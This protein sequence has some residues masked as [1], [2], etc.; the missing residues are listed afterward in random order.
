MSKPTETVVEVD[1]DIVIDDEP[2][3]EMIENLADEE[4]SPPADVPDAV[5][6]LMAHHHKQVENYVDVRMSNMM[7]KMSEHQKLMTQHT[8]AI[9]NVTRTIGDHTE[10]ILALGKQ[11]QQIMAHLVQQ[12]QPKLEQRPIKEVNPDMSAMESLFKQMTPPAPVSQEAP[13]LQVPPQLQGLVTP[14]MLAAFQKKQPGVI[15][16]TLGTVGNVLH[17]V[18]DTAAFLAESAVDLIT[19]GKAKRTK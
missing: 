13:A 15:D 8:E 1:T 14:E 6:K 11:Q 7:T 10:M 9:N 19:F 17:G 2:I 3:A 4:S 5:Q 12:S 18:V 16:N